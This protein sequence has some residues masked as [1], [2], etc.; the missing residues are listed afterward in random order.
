MI[1]GVGKHGGGGRGRGRVEHRSTP[2]S[3]PAPR[4]PCG[5]IICPVYFIDVPLRSVEQ[6]A[7]LYSTLLCS[8]LLYSLLCSSLPLSLPA[9]HK[10]VNSLTSTNSYLIPVCPYSYPWQ[11]F[12]ILNNFPIPISPLTPH[13]PTYSPPPSP[14][15]SCQNPQVSIRLPGSGRRWPRGGTEGKRGP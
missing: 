9:R 2:P 12:P 5:Y 14:F 1:C 4:P 11:L 7:L 15:T 3:L 13:S 6:R 10:A 8:T